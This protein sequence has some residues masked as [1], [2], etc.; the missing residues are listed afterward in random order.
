MTRPRIDPGPEHLDRAYAQ[1]RRPGW[2]S[3]AALREAHCHYGIVRARACQLANGEPLPPLPPLAAQPQL[4]APPLTPAANL[5]TSPA[6][7]ATPASG[8]PHRRRRSDNATPVFDTRLA[9]AGE[10]LHTDE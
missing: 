6:T 5:A 1:L 10:Y 7:P 9:A 3:L 4:R 8:P 2:P